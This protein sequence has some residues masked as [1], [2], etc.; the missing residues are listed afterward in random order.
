[1]PQMPA[2]EAQ[3]QEASL[4][5]LSAKNSTGEDLKPHSLV[6]LLSYTSS[7]T[8]DYFTA[9]KT[10]EDDNPFGL[11]VT[12]PTLMPIDGF[13]RVTCDWPFWVRYE[14]GTDDQNNEIFP[15]VGATWGAAADKTVL[16]HGRLGFRI[17]GHTGSAAD[18]SKPR[19]AMV[20]LDPFTNAFIDETY[21]TCINMVPDTGPPIGGPELD[22]FL[23]KLASFVPPLELSSAIN[24]LRLRTADPGGTG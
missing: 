20:V 18:P 15:E 2:G 3:Q 19:L 11:A 1:M 17:L 4:R 6:K 8:D 23:K 10:T 13:G 24:R 9:V 22:A 12:G 16:T 21:V 14:P 7:D 5:W